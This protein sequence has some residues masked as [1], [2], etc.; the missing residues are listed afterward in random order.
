MNKKYDAYFILNSYTLSKYSF[1]GMEYK[2][3]LFLHF[4]LQALPKW[5]ASQSPA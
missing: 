3:V 4:K 1:F 5:K 2:S